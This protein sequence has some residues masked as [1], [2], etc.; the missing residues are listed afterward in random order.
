MGRA[1][2][3][4]ALA[5]VV[6]GTLLATGIGGPHTTLVVDDVGTAL[7]AALATTG[8]WWAWRRGTDRG[9]WALLGAACLAW[10]MGEVLW[11]F[12]ELVLRR[13]SPFP[14]LADAAYLAAIP[15]ALAAVWWFSRRLRA[16]AASGL[17]ALV[18]GLIIAASLLLASWVLV[19]GPAYRTGTGGLL[20]QAISL[21]YPVGDV[22]VLIVVLSVLMHSRRGSRALVLIGIGLIAMAIADST[23]AYLTT[24]GSYTSGNLVDAGWVAA[25][26][27]IAAAAFERPRV[28]TAGDPVEPEAAPLSIGQIVLPYALAIPACLVGAN[29]LVINDHHDAVIV[30]IALSV[31]I[32]IV[33]RQLVTLFEN[34]QLNRALQTTIADLRASE[35]ELRH[36]AF[37]DPLTKLANRSLLQ[38]RVTQ[39]LLRS[40]RT[41]DGVSVIILDVDD[42]KLVNDTLGHQ[43]GDELLAAAA[44]RLRACIRRED[45]VARVGGDEFGILVAGTED[46]DRE[47]TR[48]AARILEAFRVPF[49]LR[50]H[51]VPV[52]V[53]LGIS[54][55]GDGVVD[56]DTLVR[57]ADMALYAAK[58][59]GKAR[60][61]VFVPEMR[62]VVLERL[63]LK[64]DL[65]HAV[66]NGEFVVLYQPIIELRT[67]RVTGLEALV[68]WA[69][70]RRGMLPPTQFVTI[71]E[72][73]GDILPI[74]QR[75]VEE[76]CRQAYELRE[77]M[78]HRA[79]LM[80][81]N[82][83]ARQLERAHV[84]EILDTIAASGADGRQIVFEI[85]EG[86]I[87]DD[88][89]SNLERL[90]DLK[91]HG[92]RVALDDFGTGYS[93]LSYLSRFPIDIVKLDQT[94]IRDFDNPLTVA[95]TRGIIDLAHS[96]DLVTIAE[97]VETGEQLRALRTL[98]CDEGQGFGIARPMPARELAPLLDP[99]W[100]PLEPTVELPVELPVEAPL[101][102]AAADGVVTPN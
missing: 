28:A 27:F 93:S 49:T 24:V 4:V 67:G 85:T 82:F 64:A 66:A 54:D 10:T 90:Q 88:R 65:K 15:L 7:A 84:R 101:P 60:S 11:G 23:Y 37:H 12:Y 97:G 102:E 100:R 61:E 76:A 20:E 6:F 68:R 74:G 30:F 98:G 94:F 77:S 59:Q 56:E 63:E 26:L 69:H 31:L 73:T 45:T 48:L 25:Y 47:S 87:L 46:R 1:L 41:G 75:V 19:L 39:A 79:P 50:G 55:S 99:L 91:R 58:R 83:S 35:Q 2:W 62:S 8:C 16:S 81:V 52:T 14:S 53:S 80:H 89:Q 13:D 33:L 34:R 38:D 57:N 78:G 5:V 22:V 3:A 86:V 36:L 71:A 44:E 9:A 18:D 92:S 42:F 96:L 51:Q 72:E 95:L 17:R 40:E 29:E 43:A 32:L 70:P 21:A